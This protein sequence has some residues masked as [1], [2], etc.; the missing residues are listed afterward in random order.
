MV[1]HGGVVV[2]TAVSPYR[3]TRN[4]VRNTV[5]PDNY[6]EIYVNTPLEMCKVRDVTGMYAKTRRERSRASP[7]STTLRTAPESRAC[8]GHGEPHGGGKRPHDRGAPVRG[9]LRT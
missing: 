8:P 7:A 2:C 5:G 1:R 4:D 9:F 3:A 6:I